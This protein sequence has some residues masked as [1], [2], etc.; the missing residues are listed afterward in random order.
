M[1]ATNRIFR[2]SSINIIPLSLF[3]EFAHTISQTYT[4]NFRY[5]TTQSRQD[6]DNGQDFCLAACDEDAG[7]EFQLIFAQC[8]ASSDPSQNNSFVFNPDTVQCKCKVGMRV[9][10]SDPSRCEYCPKNQYMDVL[11]YSFE[12]LDCP[13]G[14]TSSDEASYLFFFLFN[15]QRQEQQRK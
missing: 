8:N 6:T 1:V 3:H 15:A 12:C 4:H 2:T 13:F 11:S 5:I 9:D 10:S 7:F 14:K